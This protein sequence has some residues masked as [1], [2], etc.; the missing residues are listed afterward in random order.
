MNKTEIKTSI[1]ALIDKYEKARQIGKIKNYTEEDTKKDF[2]LPLF[3]LLGWDVHDRNEVSSEENISGERVDYG[4][5]LNG[6][7]R[8][9]LEAKKISVDINNPDFANQAV[10]YAWNRGVTWAVLTDFE[11]LKIF[12]AEDIKRS[13]AD[14]LFKTIHYT[15]YLSRLDELSLLSKSAI[16][17]DLL[18]KEAT[19]V[20]KI[21][22]RVPVSDT[23]YKDLDECRDILT[24]S[25]AACNPQLKKDPD[26]L[27][28]GVQKLLD[29]LIFLRVAE[30]RGVEP[31]ILKVLVREAE[32]NRKGNASLYQEMTQ[33]FRELDVAYNSNLF[34]EHP[35]EQWEEFGGVTEKVIEKLYGKKGYYEYDFKVMPAD[36]LGT[37]YEH[38][39]A[40][41]LSKSRKEI[42][43]NKDAKKRKEQGI[44]Y[45]PAFV[46]NYIVRHALQPVLNKCKTIDQLLKIKVLDPACGSGSFLIKALEI[47]T[48]KYKEL[49]HKGGEITKFIILTQ[50]LYGVDLDEKAVE[51]A[52]L[53]LC[54]NSLDRKTKL[55]F[56]TDNIKCGNS[57]I[58]GTDE[59]LK[60]YFGKD[61]RDKRPFNW[62]EEFPEVFKQGGF[63]VVIGNPPYISAVQDSKGDLTVREFYRDKFSLK[64]AFDIY[65]AFLIRGVQISNKSGSYGWIIPNKLMVAEYAKDTKKF[66]RE[67]GLHTVIDVSKLKVFGTV[68]VYPIIILGDKTRND[69]QE[70]EVE[71]IEDLH[72][73][74]FRSITHSSKYKTFKDFGFN[75]ASGAT[76]FQAKLLIN[77]LSEKCDKETIPFVVSGSIDPYRVHLDNVRYMGH[78]YEYAYIRKGDGIAESKWNFW[79]KNKI[80]ISG[81]TKR[82]EAYYSKKPLALGVGVYAIFEH[83]GFDPYFLLAVLNSKFLTY[84]FRQEFKHKHLAGGYLAINKSTLEQLPIVKPDTVIEKQLAT[85]AQQ[86]ILL[87][88]QFYKSVEN[89]NEWKRIK[90]EIEK[91]DHKIDQEVYKLYGLTSE[92]ITIIE[93][94][95]SGK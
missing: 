14:K 22:Q 28:E 64:G 87:T 2:I 63:D 33:K 25:L 17:D 81:M 46:V 19:R 82:I 49:G 27:D 41:R 51:I 37:V 72:S 67:N 5:Y 1:Q 85:L 55:P 10:R 89:S 94:E 26:L 65:V 70:Y 69:F 21:Y 57:L 31:N 42:T 23:L 35:F 76:G 47:L 6:R 3:H 60:K 58:S 40:H 62:E 80:V 91:I 84:Y 16:A 95:T 34:S 13:L 4:F 48:E 52:R 32:M 54:I 11:D 53:N 71:S 59:E 29:R 50:N 8:F 18:N 44:Y 24:K 90:S 92:E 78:N 56:L 93:S 75:I 79:N 61:Y 39:L 30:D 88:D 38:Y 36:V 66:L 73:G 86:M 15:E 43:L 20:G 68:G 12:N 77:Y 74:N 45:T 7:P 9:Y 83:N